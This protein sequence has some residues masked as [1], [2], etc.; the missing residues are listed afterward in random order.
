MAIWWSIV[1]KVR[2][3]HN[4]RKFRKGES[5]YIPASQVPFVPADHKLCDTCG[6]VRPIK[7]RVPKVKV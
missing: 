3:S 2:G 5:S 4:W 7:R 6:T 1:C